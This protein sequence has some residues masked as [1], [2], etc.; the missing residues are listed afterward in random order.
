MKS[1]RLRMPV[2]AL[3]A[4]LLL[5]S[6]LGF[7]TH[8]AAPASDFLIASEGDLDP[9][10]GTGGKLTTDFF[11]HIDLAADMVIQPDG[12]IIVVGSSAVGI[13][14]GHEERSDFAILRYNGDGSLDDSFGNGG[15][16]TTSFLG[17]PVG[18]R[19]VALYP[20]GR[21]VVVGYVDYDNDQDSDFGIAR[22]NG[23][24]SLDTTFDNDGKVITGLTRFNV[25]HH[26]FDNSAHEVAVQSDGK[27]VVAGFVG[28]GPNLGLGPDFGLARYNIDGS[29]DTNFG[30]NGMAFTDFFGH[31]DDLQALVLQPDGKIIVAGDIVN[32][33]ANTNHDFGLARYNGDGTLDASFGS[34]GKVATDFFRTSDI[35]QAID[36]QPDGKIIVAGYVYGSGNDYDFGLAR[37]NSDGSL[38]KSFGN[39]G[40]LITDFFR[41]RDVATALTIQPDGKIIA[42]GFTSTSSNPS[43]P[44]SFVALARYKGDGSLDSDF[45]VDG[46]MTVEFFGQHNSATA[47]AMQPDGKLVVAASAQ[48]TESDYDIALLRFFA[49]TTPDFTLALNATNMEAA[50][51]K[52][53]KVN[54]EIGRIGGF[55]GNVTVS[56]SDTSASGMTVT[57]SPAST[58]GSKIKFKLKIKKSAPVGTHQITF[59][60]RDDTGRERSATLSITI[61]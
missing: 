29:P 21:I 3:T 61:R 26:A 36:L 5:F 12:R 10:F 27:I 50:R 22:Y 47:L 2:F 42:G 23:D 30:T 55:T 38:D 33:V 53:P 40:K 15:I 44:N 49:F 48:K 24:G 58:T 16:V 39:N 34:G 51:G 7:W 54:L 35:A 32:L 52:K 8:A 41:G 19:S 25:G 46:K 20:D 18:A 59:T 28:G 6:S 45:G 56:V 13:T 37:Y 57:P 31:V 9:S 60:G 1:F 11:N 17:F 4:A 14:I 43:V